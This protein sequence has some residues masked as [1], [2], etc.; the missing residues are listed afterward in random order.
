MGLFATG[1]A[2][3]GGEGPWSIEPRL[4]VS[5]EYTSNPL[6]EPSG[7]QSETRAAALIDLPLR[8]DTDQLDFLLRP[9]GRFTDKSGYSALGS[10]FEHLDSSAQF[11]DEVD[12]VSLQSE[13][14]RDS[15][16]YYVG[17]LVNRVGVPRDT[18]SIASDWTRVTTERSQLQFDANWSRVRYD[19]PADFNQLVDYRYVSGGPTF[20]YSLSERNTLKVLGTYGVY[21]SLNGSTKSTSENVQLGFGRQ[22]SEIWSLSTS[23]GYSRSM[24]RENT[25]IDFFGFIFPITERS[26]QDGTVYAVTVSRQGER[27]NF[28]GGV[29]RALQPTGFAFLSNQD[30]YN[31]SASY[32][33]SERW[34]FGLSASWLKATNPPVSSGRAEFNTQ[35]ST[36][37]Y[38]NAQLAARWHWTPQW[39]VSV[40]VNRIT[41]QYGSPSVTGDSSGV[42]IDLIR[43][44]LRKHF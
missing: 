8:Y 21:E 33:R 28:S 9:N 2:D 34:D 3:A 22:L 35:E 14:A 18:A 42:S 1:A 7:A 32:T 20:A 27:L 26:T 31:V 5:T 24:N 25:F 38:L 44:F 16:L 6:L 19:E 17:G 15:S 10:N 40:T 41:Q 12:T 13:I 23:A 39:V 11:I 4:G 30:S 43:Q 29:S 37:R 36:Y